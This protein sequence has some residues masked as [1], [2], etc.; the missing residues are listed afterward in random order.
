MAVYEVCGMQYMHH[1]RVP[2]STSHSV[3]LLRKSDDYI[4]SYKDDLESFFWVLLWICLLYLPHDLSTNKGSLHNTVTDIFDETGSNTDGPAVGG[5]HNLSYLRNETRQF[6]MEGNGPLTMLLKEL[7]RT[8]R[9]R[10]PT[11][12]EEP[13]DLFAEELVSVQHAVPKVSVDHVMKC[14][15][16]TLEME[17]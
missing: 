2:T 1:V 10:Y 6:S 3:K 16:A 9:A 5:V 12:A 4:Q 8:F 15:A 7:R 13:S 17:G 11:P 14:F